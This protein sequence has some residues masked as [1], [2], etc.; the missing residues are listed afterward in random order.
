MEVN[1]KTTTK[2][3]MQDK[4]ILNCIT[5]RISELRNEITII[6]F[7]NH[8]NNLKEVKFDKKRVFDLRSKINILTEIYESN[9]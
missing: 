3:N 7:V 8:N 2:N 9:R 4:K 1:C 6:G 5:N